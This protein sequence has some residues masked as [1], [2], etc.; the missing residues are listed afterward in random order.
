M[1]LYKH[2][3]SDSVELEQGSLGV[4]SLIQARPTIS[5]GNGVTSSTSDSQALPSHLKC[6]LWASLALATVFLAG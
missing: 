4:N 1:F 3:F 6:G 2:F 5:N